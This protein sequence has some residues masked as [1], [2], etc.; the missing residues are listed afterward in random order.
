MKLNLSEA[1]MEAIVAGL[2]KE[3]RRKPPSSEVSDLQHELFVARNNKV[4][5]SEIVEIKD[6]IRRA[7]ANKKSSQKISGVKHHDYPVRLIDNNILRVRWN[8]IKLKIAKA[9]RIIFITNKY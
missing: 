1:E 5:K 9:I 4:P 8:G 7:K 6:R 2:N 3:R